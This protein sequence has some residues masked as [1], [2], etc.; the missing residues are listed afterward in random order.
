[1]FYYPVKEN[2]TLGKDNT[3]NRNDYLLLLQKIGKTTMKLPARE[4]LIKTVGFA[5]GEILFKSKT[6]GSL[7]Q[8]CPLHV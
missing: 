2:V 4:C 8:I 1:M 6:A 3:P 5:L 7:S